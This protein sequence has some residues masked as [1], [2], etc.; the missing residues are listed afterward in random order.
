MK[1][2]LM[3]VDYEN[4]KPMALRFMKSLIEQLQELID[5]NE[6]TLG[7]QLEKRIKTISS[8]EEKLKRKEKVIKSVVELDDLIGVRIIVL[9]KSDIQKVCDLIKC[10]FDI[11]DEENVSARLSDD[12]FGY[13]STHYTIQMPKSWHSLPTLADLVGLKAEIQIRTLSQHIWA[14]AS[15]KLQYKQENNVPIP[16]RRSIN[17]VSALLETVDLE[18]DRVL[19]ERQEYKDKELEN[20]NDESG[21]NVDVLEKL[22][23]ELLP[24][25]N[26]L[27]GEE[28]YSEIFTELLLNDIANAS[29]FKNL[30]NLHIDKLLEEDRINADDDFED[31]KEK[32]RAKLGV[33]YTHV[34]L[35]RGCIQNA[36]QK[37]Y[38]HFSSIK[39]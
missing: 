9:F 15:H 17:R 18:F 28:N 20:I 13:Q 2:E 34:G 24:S 30:I 12:Q 26:K 31:V 7:T 22:C 19:I 37:N 4:K 16:L 5:Q 39:K 3:R 27:H 25:Q 1:T 6:I 23:D 36:L 10:H 11:V 35:V 14:V 33:F 38:K 32:E 8:I 29:Q 21:F